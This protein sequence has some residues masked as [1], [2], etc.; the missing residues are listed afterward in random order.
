M[1]P[2]RGRALD[3]QPTNHCMAGDAGGVLQ[4]VRPPDVEGYLQKHGADNRLGGWKKRFFFTRD[5]DLF[6][7]KAHNL[8]SGEPACTATDTV[9]VI[10]L[11][12]G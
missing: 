11:E 8:R 5:R 3:A 12:D 7:A 2:C 9:G 4:A 10:P 1:R 6:Y